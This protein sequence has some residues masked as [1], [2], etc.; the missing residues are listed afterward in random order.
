MPSQTPEVLGESG[1]PMGMGKLCPGCWAICS[2]GDQCL[3]SR[4]KGPKQLHD[5]P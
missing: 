5:N 4:A 3:P 1:G 2:A